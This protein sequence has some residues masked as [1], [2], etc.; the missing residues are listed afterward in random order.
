VFDILILFLKVFQTI[1][2]IVKGM[3]YRGIQ[4]LLLPMLYAFIPSCQYWFRL[5]LS[6]LKFFHLSINLPIL[7]KFHNLLTR[8]TRL[9]K[10]TVKSLGVL[11]LLKELRTHKASYQSRTR[12][13]QYISRQ[14]KV[15]IALCMLYQRST[16]S[17][18][19]SMLSLPQNLAIIMLTYKTAFEGFWPLALR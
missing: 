13:K 17:V 12:S 11:G 1:T 19:K 7:L 4:F 8:L 9:K 6:L 15:V 5:V 10:I 16:L 3:D 18:S 14:P 2:L